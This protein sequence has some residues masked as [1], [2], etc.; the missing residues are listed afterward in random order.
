MV[1]TKDQVASIRSEVLHRARSVVR[2]LRGKSFRRC[3]DAQ[4]EIFAADRQ[5]RIENCALDPDA[6]TMRPV[7]QQ[8]RSQRGNN[9][10]MQE[11]EKEALVQRFHAAAAFTFA[12]NR[13]RVRSS[14]QPRT[15][16]RMPSPIRLAD[17]P[18]LSMT[19]E[20]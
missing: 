3:L 4:R 5:I 18:S 2:H 1:P 11:C 17:R 10:E 9:R 12:T 14:P 8:L 16:N 20:K 7:I 15:R 6:R 13:R 19:L